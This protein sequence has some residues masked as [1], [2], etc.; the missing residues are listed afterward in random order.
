MLT[1]FTLLL[2]AGVGCRLALSLALN[3][4]SDRSLEIPQALAVILIVLACLPA[5]AS[6]LALPVPLAFVL[7]A[8]LPD[9]LTRR[10]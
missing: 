6:P 4:Y 1:N 3:R 8:V 10:T 7:G 2:A 9:L 5:W